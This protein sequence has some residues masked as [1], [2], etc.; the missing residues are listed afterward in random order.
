MRRV[1]FALFVFAFAIP[2]LAG[3]NT[4]PD[5]PAINEPAADG[6]LV[7]PADVHMESSAFSD[8]DPGDQH[9]C[10][11][12]EIWTVSPPEL[13]WI[14][15]CITGVERV[16]THLGDGAFMNSHD[17]FSEL[18]PDV[19]YRLRVRHRDDSGAPAT[20]WSPFA[21]RL[22]TT[23]SQLELL[24]LLLSDVDVA[25]PPTLTTPDGVPFVLPAG[26]PPPFIRLE[27][28][29]GV[30]LLELQGADGVSNAHINPPE[31]DNHEAVR[32]RMSAG[33]LGG[34]LAFPETDLTFY[35]DDGVEHTIYLPSKAVATGTDA[36]L[37]VSASGATYE[38]DAGQ[39]APV[40][41]TLARGAPVPWI[42]RQPGYVVERVATGFQLPVNIAF[43]PNP[44]PAPAA[45]IFYVTELYGAI[46]TVHRDGT[47]HDYAAG[48]LNFNPTGNFPGSGEQGLTGITVDP[49]TGD[50]FATM[51]YDGAP[52]NGPHY[53]KIMRFTSD[54]G[55]HTA[56]TMTNIL[57]MPGE[58]QGQSHQIS[59]ITIGPDNKIYVHLGDG[60]DWTTAQN[61]NS[62]RGKILRVNL[63]GTAPTD[64]QFYSAGDG[65][66]ATDYVFA[67]GLRNPFGGAWRAADQ[68]LYELENG[69][70]VDR[71]ARVVQGRNFG[72]ND[73]NASMFNFAIY[74]WNPA[75][76]PTTGAF[77]QPETWGGSGFPPEKMD[78]L[79]VAE[80][81]P[82]YA[83]GPQAN[84]KRIS[85][86]TLDAGG[87]LL[88]GPTPLIEYAGSGKATVVALTAGPDGLYFS[89][90]YKDADFVSPIDRGASILR[91]RFVGSADFTADVTFGPQAPMT[92]RF[93]DQSNALG[94]T[95]WDWDFGDGQS[96]AEQH[97][98]H[99][100]TAPGVYDVRL[101]VTADSGLRITRK[102]GFIVVAEGGGVGLRGEYFNNIDLTNLTLTRIDPQIDFTWNG[103]APD[104]LIDA[105]TF[106]V[107][108]TG[109]VT[110][111]FSETYTFY[112][113]IDDGGR[114][115]VDGA[116]VIDSWVD[117][118]PT[119]HAGSIALTAGQ[120][121]DIVMEYY[122]N[123]GGAVA[124]LAWESPSAPGPLIIPQSRLSTCDQADLRVTLADSPDPALAGGVA[125][126]LATVTNDGPGDAHGVWLNLSIPAGLT[127]TGCA[128]SQGVCNASTNNVS[129]YLGTLPTGGM[130]TVELD[131]A[132]GG[133]AGGVFT[134]DATVE[135]NEFDPNL[136]NN[137]TNEQTAI[138]LAPVITEQSGSLAVCAGAMASFHVTTLGYPAV[139]Y[140]WRRNGDDIIGAEGPGLVIAMTDM[141]DNGAYDCV[142]SNIVDS[143]ISE[144]AVLTVTECCDDADPDHD[145]DIDLRDV[146]ILQ[147]CLGAAATGACECVDTDNDGVVSESDAMD[148]LSRMT[149]P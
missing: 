38:A 21:E 45:P 8:P 145:G 93:T 74:N 96:S 27:G 24:P 51:L 31:L 139:S 126:Y 67:Y 34:G 98:I 125:Q 87:G 120:P 97:P 47:H 7:N 5:V 89:D 73:T 82:T 142:I 60:F 149:G 16:H 33:G 100:Y 54:N 40:F 36:L 9:L 41:S 103:A 23:T 55:G 42:V 20:E 57:T 107:R 35:D 18:L 130:A 12:W 56:A 46:R 14:T 141:A 30:L 137:A 19:D 144:P 44:S 102:S 132:I 11:D 128:V 43:I 79:F 4:P 118:G 75:H 15:Q 95:A 146:A 70:S 76:A 58:N 10:S 140:Q 69:P 111:E 6:Q 61:L 32:V 62:F 116:L 59:T 2:A 106:S 101:S 39:T 123:G 84:G 85:E 17:G 119:V 25:P 72:W 129:A 52:P 90:F 121:V 136:A 117:Q 64:N 148:V 147:T 115:W 63:D 78:H 110:P 99:T 133:L 109:C 81:G 49:A 66:T 48:L 134:V 26:A 68:S 104:P 71:L 122:E 77:I 88:S 138:F 50:V 105:D 53:P 65:I 28:P 94:I 113:E 13:V 3:V 37:W 127:P 114:L 91:V 92:V 143:V 108:W 131:A 124:R 1:R 83:T 112:V 86:F 135:L 80:S 29:T 22:F